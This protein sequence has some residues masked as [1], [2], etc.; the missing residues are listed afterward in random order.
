MTAVVNVSPGYAAPRW[1]LVERGPR[2]L[3][4]LAGWSAH[5]AE[6]NP[7]PATA[8]HTA[9]ALVQDA[10][11]AREY[12]GALRLL[13]ATAEAFV[14]HPSPHTWTELC[15]AKATARQVLAKPPG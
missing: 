4:T 8:R 1:R 3:I 15:V 12:C 9:E 14:A 13:T 2:L 10:N 6:A 11:A 7:Y 5:V